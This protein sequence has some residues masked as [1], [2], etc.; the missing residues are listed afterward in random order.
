M[1]SNQLAHS[2]SPYLLQHA[3]NPV[4]WHEWNEA[5]FEKA[6]AEDKP[7]FL[8]V[9]YS[10]C[11]WCHVMERESFENEE[12]AAIMNENF[13][14][15]KVDREERPDVDKLYMLF[16]QI[17]TKSGGWP[18]SVFLTNDLQPFYGGTYFPPVSAYGRPGFPDLLRGLA[19]AWREDRENVIKSANS[20]IET[21]N[22]YVDIGQAGEF[23]DGWNAVYEACYAQFGQTFD[24]QYGGFGGAPK[25]PRPVQHDFLHAFYSLS[26]AESVLDVSFQTLR[27]M[28]DKGMNDQLGGGFHRYSVDEQWIVS[29]FE[30]ML[31]DQ[32]QLVISYLEA[33]QLSGDRYYADIAEK[34]LRYVWRDMTHIE[35][36]FFAAEDA[37]SAPRANADYKEEGAFYVWKKSE[38]EALLEQ[39]H[40]RI[41][42]DFY[43]VVPQGNAPKEGDPHGEFRGKNI[44]FESEPIQVVAKMNGITIREAL[45]SLESS[46]ETLFEAR[47]SR[48]RPHRDEKIIAYW[49]G[50]MISAFARAA[51][52]LNSTK[53]L[54]IAQSAANFCLSELVVD[55]E[56]KRHFKD[57]PASVPAFCDDYAALSRAF[58][59]LYDATFDIKWLQLAEKWADEMSVRF[60]DEGGGFY[61]SGVDPN[62]LV[63]FKED[64]DGAEPSASS[65]AV[66]VGARLFHLLGREDWREKTYQT[67]AAFASRLAGV[68]SAMPLLLRGKMILET[69]PVHI[70]IAGEKENSREILEAAGQ[71]FSVNRFVVLLNEK[72]REF[73]SSRQPFMAAMLPVNEMPTVYVCQNFACQRPVTSVA[74]M[75]VLLAT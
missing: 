38:V 45:D 32:A 12:T 16:V 15:I 21:L 5:A 59:D 35:G 67:C 49:N 2:K 7:I 66:E 47:K 31:Y 37:D 40:A 25:F 29:H 8:S 36:G 48:P 55:G 3:H 24:P 65:L 27:A 17:A 1:H 73:F 28:A 70:V 22:Q 11:H 68:P 18:M 26:K 60:Y 56:L 58:L 43:G 71:E 72:S 30:K 6:R 52:V 46:R 20:A 33:Y 63:R 57:G 14:C 4:D 74:E 42:C 10:T 75:K 44:L 50:L 23:E 53:W 69:P 19:R 39:P 9:G 54:R 64:Y 34:T 51:R 13:V 62:V 61:N 41:F